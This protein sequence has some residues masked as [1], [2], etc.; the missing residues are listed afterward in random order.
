MLHTKFHGNRSAGSG[1]EEFRRVFTIYRHGGHFGHVTIITLIYFHI[2][3]P[4]SLLTNF[5]FHM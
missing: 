4:E 1:E 3:L 5:Y 2:C